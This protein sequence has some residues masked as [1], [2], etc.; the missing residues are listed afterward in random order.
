M[1][2]PG[3]G[4]LLSQPRVGA[5]PAKGNGIAHDREFRGDRT[6]LSATLGPEPVTPTF[7][8]PFDAEN[9]AANRS[10]GGVRRRVAR[11]SA[12]AS[13]P[14]GRRAAAVRRRTPRAA[15]ADGTVTPE[16]NANVIIG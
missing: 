8:P 7:R 5:G 4:A 9:G 6:R 13:P 1:A 11:R 16:L 14:A 2:S 15:S 12:V 3:V 10:S